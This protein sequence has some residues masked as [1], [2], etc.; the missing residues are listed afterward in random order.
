M[1]YQ[2][3]TCSLTGK[4]IKADR[5]YK[6]RNDDCIENVV[7][8][9]YNCPFAD[10]E[11][12]ACINCYGTI[13]QNAIRQINEDTRRVKMETVEY[14]NNYCKVGDDYVEMMEADEF[15]ENIDII[16][17]LN[18]SNWNHGQRVAD[19]LRAYDRPATYK[20]DCLNCKKRYH[21]ENKSTPCERAKEYVESLGI[22]I[23]TASS[24]QLA[25][26]NLPQNCI[27]KEQTQRMYYV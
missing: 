12:P 10:S 19:H 2:Q 24:K 7:S 3:I 17:N 4:N 25:E 21:K 22:N 18:N 9:C 27:C 26:I 20:T 15:L 14:R 8:I 6:I 16:A 1:D 23:D 5:M 13:A 11:N